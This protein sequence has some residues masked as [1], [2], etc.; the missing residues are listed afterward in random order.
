MQW[1]DISL[2]NLNLA[3]G[4]WFDVRALTLMEE[5]LAVRVEL[6]TPGLGGRRQ[7]EHWV[8]STG[9]AGEPGGWDVLSVAS[10]AKWTRPL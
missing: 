8:I 4:P 2:G 3:A 9:A 5:P 6:L 10:S 1:L 7:V